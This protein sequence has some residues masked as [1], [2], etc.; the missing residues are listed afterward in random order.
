MKFTLKK[1]LTLAFFLLIL[2]PMVA[3]GFYSYVMSEEALQSSIEDMITVDASNVA[4]NIESTIKSVSTI[5]EVASY[6]NAL[7]KLAQHSQ[8]ASDIEAFNYIK[9]IQNSNSELIQ[10]IMIVDIRG[11][12]IMHSEDM[13]IDRDLSNED[14]VKNALSGIET[15]SDVL[16]DETTGEANIIIAYP[17]KDNN[18]VV[19]A[20]TS[21]I[22]F[23]TISEYAAKIKIG[24]KGYAYMIDK[25]GIFVYHPKSEMVFTKNIKDVGDENL[26]FYAEEA[27]TGKESEGFYE[28]EGIEKFA[29]FQPT[30]NWIVGVT[31]EYDE[32]M[33]P[34][35]NIRDN[36]VKTIIVALIISMSVA[37]Y[38]STKSIVKPIKKLKDAMNLAGE[39]D[40]SVEV[41]LKSK[42]ELKDLGDSFNGMINQLS[43]IVNKVRS[44]AHELT[45]ASE[46]MSYSAQ[47]LNSSTE[48]IGI[49][50]SSVAEEANNQ[51]KSVVEA[52]QVLVQLSS[53]VQL[54]QNKAQSSSKNANNTMQAA[55]IGRTKVDETVQAIN[56]ISEGTDET[57]QYLE[58]LN[59][60][61]IKVSGI[62]STINSIANQTNLLALNAAI[63]AARAG[64]H[65][66]GFSVVADEVRKLSEESNANASEIALIVNEMINY[67]KNAVASMKKSKD[68]VHRG[69][70]IVSETDKAFVNIMDAVKYIVSNIDEILDITKDEV[71]SS[72]QIISLINEVSTITESTALHSE[73]VAAAAEEQAA[74]VETLSATAEETSSMAEELSSLVDRFKI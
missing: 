71:A 1:K 34:A 8:D 16:M 74:N 15:V 23:N 4:E 53:L 2:L 39:G 59:E 56:I 66:R 17:L 7:G 51:N 57:A 24:E 6:N 70:I 64:V 27:K 37:Y 38:I 40:L 49:S 35:L 22:N 58:K 54:A 60:L 30:V 73:N 47:V 25:E 41:S 26:A 45:A 9:D 32:Y 10:G 67:T 13:Q 12:A 28:F 20:L 31:A 69:V 72:D 21:T 36:T 44:A 50:I 18:K 52:S 62:I 33:E 61:S 3:L 29:R 46:E 42:D 65:G 68:E 43:E 5:L 63:E 55:E 14:Y 48:E 19:G 11:K